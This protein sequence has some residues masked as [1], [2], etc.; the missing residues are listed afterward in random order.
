MRG[1]WFPWG[2]GQAG[3]TAGVIWGTSLGRMYQ[4]DL[5][6]AETE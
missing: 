2:Q 1:S 3:Y 6:G 4:L 5:R